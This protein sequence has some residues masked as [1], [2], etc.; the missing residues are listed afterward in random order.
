MESA[1][2]IIG[3][4]IMAGICLGIVGTTIWILIVCMKSDPDA[5]DEDDIDIREKEFWD[6]NKKA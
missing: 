6:K 2:E 3:T 4:I 5:E 1:I